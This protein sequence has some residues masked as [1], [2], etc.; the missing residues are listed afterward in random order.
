MLKDRQ[1]ADSMTSPARPTGRVNLLNWDGKGQPSGMF[2]APPPEPPG[3][4]RAG[5][6]GE[7]DQADEG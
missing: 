3:R 2:P 5:E 4:R 7:T 1:T 6:A